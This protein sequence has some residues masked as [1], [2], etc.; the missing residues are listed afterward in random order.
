M[1]RFGWPSRHTTNTSAKK[2]RSR[3]SKRWTICPYKAMQIWSARILNGIT[4]NFMDSIRHVCPNN[5]T[6]SF[7]AN[8]WHTATGQWSTKF[9]WRNGNLLA[10]HRW[11]RSL[12]CWWPIRRWSKVVTLYSI[13]LLDL[14]HYWW[15][16]PN[17][18]ATLLA[19]TLTFLC[20]TDER[21]RPA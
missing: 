12:V 5:L 3:K 18:V 16:P 17:A 13:R 21:N 19:P 14:D 9:R 7:S 1:C 11:M 4:L 6:T 2:R 20:S 15:R 8:V 10:T